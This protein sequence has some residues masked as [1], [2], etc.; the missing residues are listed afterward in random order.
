LI[1][2]RAAA[3]F[4]AHEQV[5]ED[6]IP[7]RRPQMPITLTEAAADRVRSHLTSRGKGEGLRLGVKTTGCSGLAYVLDYADEVSEQDR[8]F[9]SHGVKVIVDAGDMRYLDGTSID[10]MEDGLSA[11]FRFHNPNVSEQCGCGESFTVEN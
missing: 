9:T 7:I 1:R 11:A 3:I 5:P 4:D 2:N 8:V 6:G 10:F